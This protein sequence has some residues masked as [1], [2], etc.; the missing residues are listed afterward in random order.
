VK[1][2]KAKKLRGAG[3]ESRGYRPAKMR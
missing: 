1:K 2:A 3:I